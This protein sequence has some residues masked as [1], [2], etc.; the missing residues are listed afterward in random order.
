MP[1][2][3]ED[4]LKGNYGESLVATRLSAHCLVR[5]VASGTDVG[6]DLYCETVD[7]QRPFLHFWVQVKTGGQCNSKN[8]TLCCKFKRDNLEYWNRQPVPV[9]A[10]LMA[11]KWPV[12]DEPIIGIV[13]VGEW[14]LLNELP[15]NS[16]TLK[17]HKVWDPGNSAQVRE[18]L[19]ADVPAAT[20]RLH[21]KQGVVAHVPTLARQYVR[22]AP[23]VPV[24]RFNNQIIDQLRVTAALSIRFALLS[25]NIGDEEKNFVRRLA[26]IVEQFSDDPHYE[27]S[28]ALGLAAH[29]ETDYCN[30][31]R[32]YSEAR[33]HIN[34]DDAV[35]DNPDWKDEVSWIQR[36]EESARAHDDLT[37][38]L[39]N[40][41]D[42]QRGGR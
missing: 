28:L 8:G 35:R 31:E 33:R 5:P 9:F 30:A 19:Q 25:N 36:L 1:I 24:L 13:D 37:I 12:E 40:A 32:Y 27:N 34:E 42:Q 39:N 10:A 3:K 14:L 2:V 4:H 38:S 26:G 6:V 20:A 11:T 29:V 15:T 18:F 21:C 41:A 23:H 7:T 22:E 16:A 17:T